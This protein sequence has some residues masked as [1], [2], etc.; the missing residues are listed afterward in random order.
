LQDTGYWFWTKEISSAASENGMDTQLKR[1]KTAFV[2]ILRTSN[3]QNLVQNLLSPREPLTSS[4]VATHAMLATNASAEILDRAKDYIAFHKITELH[5][6]DGVRA[7]TYRLK[8]LGASFKKKLGNKE[9][10]GA[11]PGLREDILFLLSFGSE[12]EEFEEFVS[13]AKLKLAR[14][15][16]NEGAIRTHFE[17][18]YIDASRQLAGLASAS[19]GGP[20]QRIVADKLSKYFKNNANVSRV[21]SSRIRLSPTDNRQFDL[22]YEVRRRSRS[23]TYFAIEVAFQE[24]TNSVIERK[25]RQAKDLR[26]VFD[27]LGYYLCYV[28]DGAGYF[29][30]KK[31]L[32]DIINY[33]HRCVGFKNEELDS[34]CEFID[35]V[36]KT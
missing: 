25:S 31:A 15:C 8:K 35:N 28:I 19:S 11:D 9:I 26:P 4:L 18:L 16:G 34:L 5:V 10:R 14:I 24:T 6:R 13:F 7:S 3:R 21:T 36:S 22:V 32:T 29:A 2:D 12:L 33:S 30:R 20:P 17:D 1:T 27:R 23:T